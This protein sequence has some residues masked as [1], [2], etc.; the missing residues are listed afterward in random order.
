LSLTLPRA[1]RL[2]FFIFFINT[3]KLSTLQYDTE[4]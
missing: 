1:L 4:R 2:L 3:Q